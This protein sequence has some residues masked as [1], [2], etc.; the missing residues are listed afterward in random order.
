MLVLNKMVAC[1]PDKLCGSFLHGRFLNNHGG[2]YIFP[3]RK[4]KRLKVNKHAER[5]TLSIKRV[6]KKCDNLVGHKLRRSLP[7]KTFFT[8][9]HM[10]T[11]LVNIQNKHLITQ[12]SEQLFKID[13]GSVSIVR[14]KFFTPRFSADRSRH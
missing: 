14:P 6:P 12:W 5:R 2:T 9:M 4:N 1:A 10:T 13:Y 11:R 7:A 8:F 3:T